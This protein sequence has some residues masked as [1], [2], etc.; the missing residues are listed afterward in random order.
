MKTSSAVLATAVAWTS[1]VNAQSTYSSLTSSYAPLAS[2]SSSLTAKYAAPS[3]APGYVARLVA[4]DL[5]R[6]RGIKFDNEGNLLVV[7]QDKGIAAL[8]LVESGAG[9]WSV[10]SRRM[11][12]D[13]PSLN[14]GIVSGLSSEATVLRQKTKVNRAGTFSRWQYPLCLQR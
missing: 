7:E 2:C 6:P 4:Q 11:V 5:S 12:I 1:L 8:T 9:C 10:S 14:H 13:E 3:V